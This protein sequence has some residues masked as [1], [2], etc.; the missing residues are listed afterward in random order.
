MSI[1]GGILWLTLW[2][3]TCFSWDVCLEVKLKRLDCEIDDPMSYV[4]LKKIFKA[5]HNPF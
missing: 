5:D 2:R 1:L 3:L 4:H